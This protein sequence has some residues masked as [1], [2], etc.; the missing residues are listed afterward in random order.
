MLP[1]RM[2]VLLLT[3]SAAL[4]AACLWLD[5][6][7]REWLSEHSLMSNVIAGVPAIPLGAVLI[8]L[9]VDRS[10]SRAHEVQMNRLR[11][12]TLDRMRPTW[13]ELRSLLVAR[14]ALDGSRPFLADVERC[15]QLWEELAV[16]PDRTILMVRGGS[17]GVVPD[18]E[19]PQ[20]GRQALEELVGHAFAM[21]PAGYPKQQSL[22]QERLLSYVRQLESVGDVALVLSLR[23]LG[24]AIV[25]HRDALATLGNYHDPFSLV[26]EVP[27]RASLR[28]IAETSLGTMQ[29]VQHVLISARHLLVTG[30]NLLATTPG[31]LVDSRREG[32]LESTV[33]QAGSMDSPRSTR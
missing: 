32:V 29:L 28:N 13:Q 21:N 17:G 19:L 31:R 18:V 27:A 23:D 12:Q 14:F 26:R 8:S 1:V 24:D 6:V 9:F 22:L 30:D 25:E 2:N 20:D 3:V 4:I 11:D 5:T 7:A 33:G 16:Q 10:V 15:I